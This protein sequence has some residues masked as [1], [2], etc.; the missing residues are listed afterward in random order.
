[1]SGYDRGYARCVFCG[2]GRYSSGLRFIFGATACICEQC[3]EE[4]HTML[5]AKADAKAETARQA[6]PQ[7]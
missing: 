4:C 7:S 3:V 2:R 6:E 1:M 5:E